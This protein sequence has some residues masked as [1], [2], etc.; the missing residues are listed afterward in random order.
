MSTI[1]E[2]LDCLQTQINQL[3]QRDVEINS[4]LEPCDMDGDYIVVTAGQG[5][6]SAS[7]T[8]LA[9]MILGWE[10]DFMVTAGNNNYPAGEAS[11]IEAN[12]AEFSTLVDDAKVYPALG[13]I[14]NDN[15]V[16]GT[17]GQPQ[18]DKFF[19][20]PG[21]KRYY[22]V[23][24]EES[25]T[26]LFVLNSGYDSAGNVVEP[27]G[28][29]FDSV[30]GLWFSAEL[31]AT[32]ARNK[33]VI[34]SEGFTS[35][36]NVTSGVTMRSDMLWP[37]MEKVDLIIN[38][39]SLINEAML[40]RGVPILAVNSLQLPNDHSSTDGTNS[41]TITGEPDDTGLIY[42]DTIFAEGQTLLDRINLPSENGVV[43]K[44]WLG[45]NGAIMVEFWQYVLANPW[46]YYTLKIK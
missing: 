18:T 21:C 40:W 31:E 35:N 20:L 25:D 15:T 44:L 8:D 37:D 14:D 46:L 4:R 22:T 10:P 11:T 13:P 42:R 43:I 26:Q 2:A 29:T 5:T 36:V 1:Q 17:P 16:S 45:A 33:V 9:G 34:F 30:Q 38:G 12:W 3:A 7:Q 27:D 28:N 24:L 41:W 19:Y 32:K 6:A 39:N 23:Y